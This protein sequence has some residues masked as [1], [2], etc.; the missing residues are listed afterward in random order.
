LN[1]ERDE[2]PAVIKRILEHLKDKAETTALTVLAKSRA[3]PDGLF[4]QGLGSMPTVIKA[5]LMKERPLVPPTQ[6]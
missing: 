2:A 1:Q 4:D 6:A 3:P 5:L